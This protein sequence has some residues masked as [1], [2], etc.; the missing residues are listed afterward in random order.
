MTAQNVLDRP[1]PAATPTLTAQD[2]C[3]SRCGAQAYV[4]IEYQVGG[5][6]TDLRLCAHHYD[7]HMPVLAH[8]FDATIL[9]DH[10]DRLRHDRLKD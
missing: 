4:L 7:A 3:E 9:V 8:K 2:R 5:A 10:R 1:T 6:A